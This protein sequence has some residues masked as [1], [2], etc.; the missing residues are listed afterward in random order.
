[1][2]SLKLKHLD[3][4]SNEQVN[5]SAIAR[6][7][8]KHK[9][10]QFWKVFKFTK[11]LAEL[12]KCI[13]EVRNLDLKTV[14]EQDDYTIKRPSSVDEI[15]LIAMLE[16]Q[17]LFDSGG[18]DILIGE[19]ITHSIAI[20]CFSANVEGNFSVGSKEF[21]DFK[22]QVSESDLIGAMGLYRWISETFSSSA[23]DWNRSFFEVEI[24]NKEYDQAGG[25]MLDKF[26]VL[27]TI[28]QTCADF[29][30]NYDDALQ[31]PYGITQANSLYNATRNFVESRMTDIAEARMKTDRRNH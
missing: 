18:E 29:N 27:A 19:L 7:L 20:V 22:K 15:T 25:Q 17:G 9:R 14:E 26:N 23:E 30:V 11:Q 2:I 24:K 8:L 28:R 1:M 31:M 16:L 5:Y 21:A 13:T 10:W 4:V 3:L 12:D 6:S